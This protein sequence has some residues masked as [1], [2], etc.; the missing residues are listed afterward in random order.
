MWLCSFEPA[1]WWS[2]VWEGE[3]HLGLQL[4]PLIHQ[5][6]QTS[7]LDSISSKFV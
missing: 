7:L 1:S 4:I 2:P 3:L 5:I 6:N